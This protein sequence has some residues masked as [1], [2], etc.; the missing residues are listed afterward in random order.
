MLKDHR[1]KRSQVLCRKAILKAT[2]S[3]TL[4]ETHSIRGILLSTLQYFYEQLFCRKL[5]S[6]YEWDHHSQAN[7]TARSKSQQKA[8]DK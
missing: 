3:A 8:I 6:D 1:T 5:A 7:T 4:L 2:Q